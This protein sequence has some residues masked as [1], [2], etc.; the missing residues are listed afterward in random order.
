MPSQTH[1]EPEASSSLGH[2]NTVRL[3]PPHI[4]TISSYDPHLPAGPTPFS[5][6]SMAAPHPMTP[7]P[8]APPG[9]GLMGV[10]VPVE[11]EGGEQVMLVYQQQL[12]QKHLEMAQQQQ[13]QLHSAIP[14][15]SHMPPPDSTAAAHSSDPSQPVV[16]QFPSADTV[17]RLMSHQFP[18]LTPE[19][20]SV[21]Q[22]SFHPM[23]TGVATPGMPVPVDSRAVHDENPHIPQ[24]PI[25]FAV[26]A[27]SL[28][29][30]QQQQAA[31]LM[32][33][34]HL[35]HVTPE[36]FAELKHHIHQEFQKNPNIIHQPQFQAALQQ[37]G[38]QEHYLREI[39]L[40]QEVMKQQHLAPRPGV[41]MN[42]K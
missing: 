41:I 14:F 2:G 30:L 3:Q 9:I 21:M 39:M 1:N 22:P 23:I 16:F 12:F 6:L 5:G 10:P 33:H 38:L 28:E 34:Q 24:R 27:N 29:A 20:L 36:T 40:Q 15:H 37:V 17:N 25:P 31:M 35:Q 42:S 26:P 32:Q 4:P 11:R 18:A 7:V 19:G 13:Q 8:A